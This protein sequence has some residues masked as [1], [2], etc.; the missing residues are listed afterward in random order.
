MIWFTFC[1][2]GLW[3]GSQGFR[4]LCLVEAIAR[5]LIVNMWR[6]EATY[7]MS[8]FVAFLLGR[9]KIDT[10]KRG[11][12][13]MIILVIW[14]VLDLASLW[15][16]VAYWARLVLVVGLLSYMYSQ[17]SKLKGSHAPRWALKLL[18][19]CLWGFGW[20][21]L[22]V[23]CILEITTNLP[24]IVWFALYGYLFGRSQLA[25]HPGRKEPEQPTPDVGQGV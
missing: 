12:M 2:T 25:V 15:Y 11:I 18:C 4:V 1:C 20:G 6:G 13:R 14:L 9:L 16:R 10:S 7:T 22:S 17:V 23:M 3:T 19:L 8:W 24:L 5:V 21:I